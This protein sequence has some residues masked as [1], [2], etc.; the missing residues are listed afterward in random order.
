M[1]PARAIP[2]AL[3]L[4]WTL[5]H[6]AG[7]HA[8]APVPSIHLYTI[9]V[10]AVRVSVDALARSASPS[11][12]AVNAAELQLRH[13]DQVRLLDN[14]VMRTGNPLL[15]DQLHKGKSAVVIAV[16]QELDALDNALQTHASAPAN[17]RQLHSLDTI[18]ASPR[19]HARCRYLGCVQQWLGDRVTGVLS[20]IANKLG[21]AFAGSRLL[22][23]AG[24]VLLVAGLAGLVVRGALAQSVITVSQQDAGRTSGLRRPTRASASEYAAAG[25]YRTALR[26]LFLATIVELQERGLLD[27]QPGLT[28]REYILALRSSLPDADAAVQAPLQEMVDTFDRA[29][30]GH[31]DLDAS[32]YSHILQVADRLL[33]AVAT[34]RAA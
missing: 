6:A 20:W 25:D 15:A 11:P 9:R 4:L 17:P 3:L 28:N 21:T 14:T 2:F 8:A 1:K 27:P 13:L 34:V 7:A 32:E 29:W 12:S 10:H 18:L 26:H 19:F 24:F 22:V 30:Y 16:A 23:A 31:V 5:V 33:A